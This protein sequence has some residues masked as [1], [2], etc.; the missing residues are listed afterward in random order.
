M[1]EWTN[2]ERMRATLAGEAAD[3]VPAWIMGFF[4]IATIRNLIPAELVPAEPGPRPEV[5]PFGYEALP[6]AEIDRLVAFNGY[7]DR[8]ATAA[9][10]GANNGFGH[11]GPGEF[12]SFVVEHTD[13]YNIIEYE[14]GA[15][16]KVQ[17]TPHF[18]HLFDMPVKTLA[19]L[20][21]VK[22]P[23]PEA[24]ARWAGFRED[25][26]RL[27]ARGEYVI[28]WVNGIFSGLHY[29]YMDY[30]DVMAALLLDPDLI[31]EMVNRLTD[32]NLRAARML[33]ESGVDCVGFVDDMGSGEN[34]LFRPAL[35]DRFFFDYHRQMCDLV[36]SYGAHVHMHSHGNINK[37]LPRIVESGVD[38]LNP[39]DPIE[40]MDLPAIKERFPKLTVVGGMDKFIWDQ[41]LPEIE[42][43]LTRSVKAA[44]PGR[45]ILMDTGG[46]PENMTREKF[47][48]FVEI[49]RRA[50]GQSR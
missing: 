9:G 35:Y 31:R 3:Y 47:A 49:S 46:V 2:R 37:I 19:D 32:W 50:R 48:S 45:F 44:G 25:V 16:A 29:F 4:N 26:R 24:P 34:L 8:V 18:Y 39:M 17:F 12:N 15:K 10:H 14:T 5:H 30:Q 11:G 41:E 40:G 21:K 7:F 13:E 6:D 28:G 20:E 22:L 42:E 1:A 43:R 33:L 23:D 27:K 38:M 36:H